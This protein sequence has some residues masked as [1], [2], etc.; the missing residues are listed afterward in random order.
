MRHGHERLFTSPVAMVVK[1]AKKGREE[2]RK[3]G[4]QAG[5]EKEE[6]N[7]MMCGTF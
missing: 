4:T 3:G 6:E 1:L 7:W 5:E 2:W